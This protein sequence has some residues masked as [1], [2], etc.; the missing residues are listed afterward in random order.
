MEHSD[1]EPDVDDHWDR[2][3]DYDDEYPEADDPPWRLHFEELHPL[4]ANAARDA[5]RAENYSEA[6]RDAWHALRDELRLKLGKP[7]FEGTQLIDA[8]G[9]GSG[10]VEPSLPLTEYVNQTDKSMHRGLVSLLRGL[11]MYV[12]H[13]EAHETVSPA[14]GDR[15]AALERLAVMSICARHVVTAATPTAIEDAISE[16]VQPRFPR[17]G[18]AFDDLLTR[19]PARRH[20]E[21][22]VRV[23]AEAQASWNKGEGDR[24]YT[25]T[26]MYRHVVERSPDRSL[27]ATS[28]L[29]LGRLIADDG[30]LVL[31]TTLATPETA[32][33]LELRHR[34]K[35]ADL[36][37]EE[38]HVGKVEDVDP[39]RPLAADLRRLYPVLDPASRGRALSGLIGGLEDEDDHRSMYCYWALRGIE[40]VLGS[41]ER[42]VSV[43]ALADAQ[44]QRPTSMLASW[45]RH[46]P[47]KTGLVIEVDRL[48]AERTAALASP[49]PAIDAKEVLA[50]ARRVIA[51]AEGET[52]PDASEE[53]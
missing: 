26:L 25:L 2:Y 27:V 7:Y 36:L 6:L 49:P 20:G 47:E 43:R 44:M 19:L 17:R 32:G 35:L 16:L 12:R 38:A 22:A 8:I 21:F 10:G 37:V 29:E 14:E 33:H 53:P 3:A 28:A 30:T 1:S 41:S 23:L 11:L 39:L 18:A 9:E 15:V 50:Q 4:I 5:W 24:Y 13:P 45:L 42:Q 40:N 51:K 48:V 52:T 31:G 34:H 46:P